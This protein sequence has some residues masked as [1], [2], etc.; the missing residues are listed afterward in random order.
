MNRFL[1]FTRMLLNWL[2]LMINPIIPHLFISGDFYFL[3]PHIFP[4]SLI[5]RYPFQ[6]PQWNLASEEIGLVFNG[7]AQ[8]N[9][10]SG[11]NCAMN[12]TYQVW[13][14]KYQGILGEIVWADF[15]YDLPPSPRLS[16][17]TFWGGQGALP[18]PTTPTPIHVHIK[19]GNIKS[20]EV[21]V[22]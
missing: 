16:R 22:I 1:F 6:Q 7:E 13:Q 9:F 10:W 15:S 18:P 19:Y 14:Y 11:L 4:S 20:L 3:V 12:Y 21:N 5:Q 8:N 17:Q 2:K